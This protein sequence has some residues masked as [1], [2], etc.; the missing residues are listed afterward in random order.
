MNGA[1][2]FAS[3]EHALKARGVRRLFTGTKLSRDA[4]RLF[5]RSGWDEAERLFIKYIG[6]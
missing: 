5:E 4:S 1:N 3:A 6:D 2:L